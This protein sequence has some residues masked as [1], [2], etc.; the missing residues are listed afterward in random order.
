MQ[1]SGRVKSRRAI[2]TTLIAGIALVLVVG[3]VFAVAYSSRQITTDAGSLHTADETLR[4]AT[5]AR[6]QLALAVHASAVDREFGTDS[7]SVIETAIA[8]TEQALADA[9]NGLTLGAHDTSDLAASGALLSEFVVVAEEIATRLSEGDSQGAQDLSEDLDTSFRALLGELS[10]TRDEIAGRASSS[11]AML[12]RIGDMARFL[13]AFL[14]PAAVI[15]IYREWARRQQRQSELEARLANERE[16]AA[17]REQFIANASHELRTPLTGIKGLAMLLE[18]DPQIESSDTAAELVDLIVSEAEDLS[19]MVEDLLTAA[20]LDA[21]A[22]TYSFEDVDPAVEAHEVVEP[23]A[24]NGVTIGVTCETGTVRADRLRLRQI[25]RNL[26]SNA[27]KYGGPDIRIEGRV[28]DRT[29]VC[30][31]I[32]NGSGIPDEIADKVFER[33][34]HQGQ[35]TATKDSVGLGLSIV[36][37]LADG[38]GGVVRYDRVGDETHFSLRIPLL[39]AA[40]APEPTAAHPASTLSAAEG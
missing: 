23:L 1:A 33:F 39:A 8:E 31:V 17:A 28:V 2:A 40:A 37:A 22:L 9:V 29:Y 26:V 14:V 24:R 12:G 3:I 4:S 35:A 7:R 15:F 36:K 38:M 25:V 32:D 18:E 13:V 16:L 21:G 10:Q 6:A 5:V 20:R 19:R 34:I 27:R 30:S 11:D